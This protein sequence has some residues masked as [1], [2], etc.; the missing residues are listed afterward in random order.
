MKKVAVCVI[1]GR[2]YLSKI[3]AAACLGVILTGVWW[4]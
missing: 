3:K 4:F 1:G 2:I